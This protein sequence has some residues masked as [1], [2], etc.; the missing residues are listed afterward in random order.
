MRH[1]SYTREFFDQIDRPR[2]LIGAELFDKIDGT[3]QHRTPSARNGNDGM[4]Y[5]HRRRREGPARIRLDFY[6][7]TNL[8]E[9]MTALTPATIAAACNCFAIRRAA[10]SIA[11]RYDEAF[12]PLDLNNGQFSMLVAVA[13]F[14]TAGIQTLGERLG[15]D[16]TTV[17]AALKPLQRRGLVQVDIA[18]DDQRGRLVRLTEAGTALLEEAVPLWVAIQ[19][20]VAQKL[21]GKD[22]SDTFRRQLATLD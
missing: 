1:E 14:Q 5:F 16:R 10:R 22:M 7:D 19:E 18:E 12:R 8:N 21:G 20:E 15:M 4:A 3:G 6:V 17:T 9:H 13:G 11:R 2:S